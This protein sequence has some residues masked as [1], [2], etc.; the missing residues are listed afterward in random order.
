MVKTIVLLSILFL[1]SCSTIKFKSSHT[2]P[3]SFDVR[4]FQT[5]SVSIE[6]FKAFYMW[7]L[8]PGEQVVELDQLFRKK[9]FDSVSS[10]EIKETKRTNK[11]IWM[12]LTLGMY[13]PEYYTIEAKTGT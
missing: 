6:V 9:G 2:I 7:G 11:M 10:I 4:D 12:I 5:K 1:I 13:Y 8:V 3:V